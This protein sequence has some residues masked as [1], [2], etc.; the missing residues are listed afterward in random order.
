M[1]KIIGLDCCHSYNMGIAV[2]AQRLCHIAIWR[3]LLIIGMVFAVLV[4]SQCFALLYG[5]TFSLYPPMVVR[6]ATLLISSQS[7]KS[8]VAN[9][10]V[11]NDTYASDSDSAKET[12]YENETKETDKH[13]DPASDDNTNSHKEF[14]FEKDD[15]NGSTNFTLSEVQNQA[16]ILPVV[17]Q[18]I[19]TKGMG[20]FDADSRTSDSFFIDKISVSPSVGNFKQTMGLQPKDKE[21]K[22]LQAVSVTLNNNSTMTS[23]SNSILKRWEKQLTSISQINSILL[24]SHVSSHSV[25]RV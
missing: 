2:L 25:V 11:G 7:N 18:G 17:S 24:H 23:I 21:M 13:N 22:P 6:N 15:P 3:L 19:S 4:V 20:N 10:L 8:F 5:K 16:G 9:L 12:G 1:F 14:K